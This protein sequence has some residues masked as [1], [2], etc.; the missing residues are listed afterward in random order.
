VG[1]IILTCSPGSGKTTLI[2]KLHH[3]KVVN[4]GSE[5]LKH[6]KQQENRD[7]MRSTLSSDETKQIRKKV[8]HSINDIKDDIILDTHPAIKRGN[9]YIVGF[10]STDL[11]LLKDIKAIIYLDAAAVDIL[12]RRIGDKTRE[13]EDETAEEI[14]EHRDVNIS[15]ATYYAAHL[16]VPLYIIKNRQSMLETAVKDMESAIKEAFSK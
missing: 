7:K 10:S 15:L 14:D 12:L 3:V 5:M 6:V 16:G 4:V 8:I 2:A 9:R 11:D 13:R 1:K